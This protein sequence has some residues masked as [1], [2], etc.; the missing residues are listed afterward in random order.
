MNGRGCSPLDKG[1]PA[2]TL[3]RKATGLHETAGPPK[4]DAMN[5]SKRS[6]QPTITER[7]TS[8]QMDNGQ[9]VMTIA[10]GRICIEILR[11]NQIIER[12]Y[13]EAKDLAHLNVDRLLLAGGLTWS[14]WKKACMPR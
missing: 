12:K 4:E 13:F 7:S 9:T 1:K 2:A 5:P 14:D 3:G 11:A 8:A 10:D 6:V